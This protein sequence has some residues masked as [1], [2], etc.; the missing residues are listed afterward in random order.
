MHPRHREHVDIEIPVFDQV[1]FHALA[2][3]QCI[4][5][6]LEAE[7][8][9]PADILHVLTDTAQSARTAGHF[10]DHLGDT[11]RCALNVGALRGGERPKASPA[12]TGYV[13]QRPLGE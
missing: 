4:H 1:L 12:V 10:N 11:P 2:D 3:N 8:A 9:I 13:Q 7:F 6:G 5:V